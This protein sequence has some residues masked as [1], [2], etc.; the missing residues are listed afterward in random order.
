MLGHRLKSTACREVSV[1][2]DWA[3]ELSDIEQ[4]L[5]RSKTLDFVTV[6]FTELCDLSLLKSADVKIVGAL[7]L[8]LPRFTVE[9]SFFFDLQRSSCSKISRKS[10]R[11]LE[12][13]QEQNLV[14]SCLQIFCIQFRVLVVMAIFDREL[15]QP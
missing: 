13:Y 1:V 12:F 4:C 15:V 5:G 7:Q 6:P 11:K 9:V 14:W 2:D 3:K 10:R 8:F